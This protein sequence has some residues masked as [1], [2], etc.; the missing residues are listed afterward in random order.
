MVIERFRPGQ[1]AEVYARLRGE[2]RQIP[3]GLNYLQSWVEVNLLRCFQLM[4]TD[5][6]ALFQEWAAHWGELADIEV[7]PVT[8]SSEASA[9][10]YRALG[11]S[12][13]G[14]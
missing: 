14:S 4:E 2:G 8:P 3:D 12:Q 9:A 10:V 13:P 1:M 6:P 5:N 7:V 11:L